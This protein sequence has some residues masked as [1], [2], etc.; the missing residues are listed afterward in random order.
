MHTNLRYAQWQVQRLK[1]TKNKKKFSQPQ[2]EERQ[3]QGVR[4]GQILAYLADEDKQQTDNITST[5]NV[6]CTNVK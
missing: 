3:A 2:R 5:Q 4:F 6:M 1:K